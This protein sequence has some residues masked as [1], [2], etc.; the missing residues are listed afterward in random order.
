MNLNILRYYKEY[1]MT[2]D[3]WFITDMD[4]FVIDLEGWW[5]SDSR[6][7]KI[8]GISY[9]NT[10]GANTEKLLP[11]LVSKGHLSPFE[12]AGLTFYL[13]IPIFVA[14][15]LLRYRHISVNEMSRRY[16]TDKKTRFEFYLPEELDTPNDFCEDSKPFVRTAIIMLVKEYRDYLKRGVKPELARTILPVSLMTKM[17]LSTNIRELMH[18]LYQRTKS[19]AQKEI[20]YVA[21]QMENWL[22]TFFPITYKAYKE[23]YKE[24]V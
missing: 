10:T 14:R 4:G 21:K 18:I 12:H 15:Q 11:F 2:D 20:Q 17:Y 7:A 9:G 23:L 13:E 19:D 6:I 16:T 8:A 1:L 22:E 3:V 24:E 5:G